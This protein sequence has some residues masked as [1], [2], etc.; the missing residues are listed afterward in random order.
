MRRASA[1]RHIDPRSPRGYYVDHSRAAG[2]TAIGADGLPELRRPVDGHTHSALEVARWGLGNLELYL[3]SGNTARRDGFER[4]ARFLI[5]TIEVVPSSFGG[6]AMP[7]APPPYGRLLPRGHFAAG[8]QGECLSVVVR[9]WTLLGADGAEQTAD[10]A[11]A[12]LAA[13]IADGGLLREIGEPTGVA[14]LDSLAF[15]EEYPL[16]E[17]PVM[18]LSG[19]VRGLLGVHD[20]WLASGDPTAG[21]LRERCIRGLAFVLD[22][23]DLGY[24][25]L[26]DLDV[27]APGL[28]LSSPYALREHILHAFTLAEVFNSES[29]HD[30]ALRWRSY[31]ASPLCRTQALVRRAA[32]RLT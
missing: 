18:D 2:P 29:F 16:E 25:T 26:D 1:G 23:F 9:A 5:D 19:H 10:R 31:Q 30:A 22:R 28:S 24:W 17:R 13:P 3:E 14:G 32:G 6:W 11:A 20:Y 21:S 8:A 27:A 12:A 7:P 15:L 4:A